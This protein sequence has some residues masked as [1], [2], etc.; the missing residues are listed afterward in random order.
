MTAAYW[1]E[2]LLPMLGNLSL[3]PRLGCA[4]AGDS[5]SVGNLDEATTEALLRLAGQFQIQ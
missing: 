5:S 2:R 4:R 3:D 1:T